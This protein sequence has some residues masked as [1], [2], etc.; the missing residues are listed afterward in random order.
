MEDTETC[1]EVFDKAL[2]QVEREVWERVIDRLLAIAE[3]YPS[4]SHA[5]ATMMRTIDWC[6]AKQKE[7][8]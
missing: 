4:G 7:G 2:L 3:W 8:L 5:H 1:L 6:R